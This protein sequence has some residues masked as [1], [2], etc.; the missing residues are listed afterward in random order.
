MAKALNWSEKELH[1][2]YYVSYFIHNVSTLVFIVSMIDIFYKHLNVFVTLTV[3]YL[4]LLWLRDRDLLL[5]LDL[6]WL[7]FLPR[8]K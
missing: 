2:L 7:R 3:V 5:D 6:E 1:S 8:G 4:D